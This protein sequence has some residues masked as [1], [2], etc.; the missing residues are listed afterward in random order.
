M[1]LQKADMTSVAAT[2]A[3]RHRA[4]VG[5]RIDSRSGARHRFD[6]DPMSLFVKKPIADLL[7]EAERGILRRSLGPLNLT[8]LGIGSVIG[9][10]IFVLT[11]E[12]PR[13]R[14]LVRR[15]VLSMIIGGHA[16]APSQGLCYAEFAAMV[17]VAGS[18][19]TGTRTRRVGE[20]FAWIIGWDSDAR[21][22][23]RSPPRSPSAGRDTSASLHARPGCARCRSR[24]AAPWGTM[25]PDGAGGGHGAS[26]IQRAGRPDVVAVVAM[27]VGP[28]NSA[29][30]PALNTVLVL[31]Q[32]HGA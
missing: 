9:T 21:I 26:G 3:R 23:A 8:A 20:L 27:A 25:V 24:S 29:N 14:T 32:V 4:H 10:G 18:A 1:V 30:R 19:Y 16:P 2:R 28:R 11:G 7:V 31:D 17:P 15:L 6:P 22:R 12:R 13:P 5:D